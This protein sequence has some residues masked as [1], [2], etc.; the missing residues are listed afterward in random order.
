MGKIMGQIIWNATS[1]PAPKIR[2]F[3]AFEEQM[4]LKNSSGKMASF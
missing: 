3:H 4:N 1:V 2:I